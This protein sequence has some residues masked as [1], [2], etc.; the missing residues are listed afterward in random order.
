MIDTILVVCI[1]SIAGIFVARKLFKQ[2]TSKQPSC[3]CTGC[4]HSGSCSGIQ[5]SPN[6]DSC[7]GA[8]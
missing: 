2:F 7:P 6:N 4:G 1:V 3:N 5:D 8:Q